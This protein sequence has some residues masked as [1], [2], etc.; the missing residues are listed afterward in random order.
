MFDREQILWSTG[1]ALH[2][3]HIVQVRHPDGE[4]VELE[5]HGMRPE[6]LVVQ[7]R[8]RS[9]QE[10]EVAEP[11][12]KGKDIPGPKCRAVERRPDAVGHPTTN[13]GEA[14]KHLGETVEILPIQIEAD[15]E[16]LGDERG[17]MGLRGKAADHHE[18]DAASDERT[19]E[20]PGR[21]RGVLAHS[22]TR[23]R[24]RRNSTC[25]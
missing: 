4:T 15:V 12:P 8:V 16:I 22:A 18:V 25:C 10:I 21:E 13:R 7:P 24:L 6:L 9:R 2:R 14:S 1:S 11:G 5:P 3:D 17:S 20:R 19:K 23:F